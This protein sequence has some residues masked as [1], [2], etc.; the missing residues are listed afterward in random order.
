VLGKALKEA[1]GAGKGIRRYGWASVPMDEALAQV[2]LDISGRAF[3]HYKA[4][5]PKRARI[6]NFDLDLIEDFLHALVANAGFTLHAHILYGRN[7]HHMAEALFK[8][9]AVALREAVRLEDRVKGAP[10]TKGRL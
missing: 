2:S 8:A 1:L 4:S 7:A 9:L 5:F 3:L 6:K 10:S